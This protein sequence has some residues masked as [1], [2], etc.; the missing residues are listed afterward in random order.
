MKKGWSRQ[1]RHPGHV[2]KNRKSRDSFWEWFCLSTR[3]GC[4]FGRLV[5]HSANWPI[6]AW[7]CDVPYMVKPYSVIEGHVTTDVGSISDVD[8]PSGLTP[9]RGQ[10]RTGGS[11][12]I[13]CTTIFFLS[14][15]PSV[16]SSHLLMSSGGRSL[17]PDDKSMSTVEILLRTL[18]VVGD[19][20]RRLKHPFL[21]HL[22]L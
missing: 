15:L 14:F 1:K 5:I 21:V 9:P 11:A 16:K 18:S 3:S 8:V 19:E 4:H 17:A 7:S 2:D 20:C 10:S 12:H 6:N 13:V 22:S